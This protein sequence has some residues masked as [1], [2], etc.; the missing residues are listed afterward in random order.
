MDY[1]ELRQAFE[2]KDYIKVTFFGLVVKISSIRKMYPGG[3]NA[4][5]ED[6][7]AHCT[8]ELAGMCAMSPEYLDEPSQALIDLGFEWDKDMAAVDALNAVMYWSMMEKYKKVEE[9]LHAQIPYSWLEGTVHDGC[10]HVRMK[11]EGKADS[12]TGDE[13]GRREQ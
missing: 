8:R 4:F 5:V 13:E 12:T 7:C 11:L 9:P 1:P 2:A 3:L 10:V 6:H